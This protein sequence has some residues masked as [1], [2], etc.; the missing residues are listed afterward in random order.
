MLGYLQQF[1]PSFF[2]QLALGS[3]P[4]DVA[5]DDLVKTVNLQE[6]IERLVLR[7][8]VEFQ[9]HFTLHVGGIHYEVQARDIG[10]QLDYFVEF[11]VL[12]VE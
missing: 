5:F 6:R 3:D 7:D 8:V 10:E 11:G 2:V 12:D 1:L 9:G 4:E